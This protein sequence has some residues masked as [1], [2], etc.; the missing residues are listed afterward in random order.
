RRA[1]SPAGAMATDLPCDGDGVCMVCQTKAPEEE[2]VV[3]KTC[4]TPWHV[5]CLSKPPESL[6]SVASWEGPD[7]APPPAA[8]GGGGKAAPAGV[9]S[10][11][12]AAIRAIEADA[13]L[14]E[15]EKARKRQELVSGGAP[16]SDGEEEGGKGRKQGESD[17]LDLLDEKFKCAICM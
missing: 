12:V 2:A 1:S 16:A 6:A 8:G 11:L 13:G 15:Q 9:A 14:T 10:D 4:A 3:C 5:P 7:C 17:V